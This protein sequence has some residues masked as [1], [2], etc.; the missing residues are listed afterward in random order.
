MK[1]KSKP[2]K[3]TGE[4]KGYGCGE[5][6]LFRRYGLCE[7][8]LGSWYLNSEKGRQKLEKATLKVTKPKRDLEEY[9]KSRKT[10]EK[11]SYLKHSVLVWCHK[12]IKLRDR[13]KPC[14]S[15][16][17]PWHSDHQAGHWKKA[18]DYSNLKFDERNIHNQCEGCNIA[19]QGNVQ[20][21]SIRITQ[22]ISEEDKSELERLAAEYKKES[23]HWDRE[24]L[25]QTREYYK[26]KYNELKKSIE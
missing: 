3:G 12:Y 6:I 15:C 22:R 26:N 2:C 25:K 21:Y 9:K 10:Q 8:C 20:A 16:G 11:L 5:S 24:T 1:P 4:A 14:V 18:S 19:K 7:S 13:G 23:F 17:Q